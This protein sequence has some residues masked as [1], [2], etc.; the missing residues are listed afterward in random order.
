M[1]VQQKLKLPSSSSTKYAA[2]AEK[3]LLT[4]FARTLLAVD[5]GYHHLGCYMTFTA[6]RWE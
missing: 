4:I 1:P 3:I 5:V 2:A 6:G